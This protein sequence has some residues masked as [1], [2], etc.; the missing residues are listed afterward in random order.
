MNFKI[1][2]RT[3]QATPQPPF[4]RLLKVLERLSKL[5]GPQ[6]FA[7]KLLVG[8]GVDQASGGEIAKHLIGTLRLAYDTFTGQPILHFDTSLGRVDVRNPWVVGGVA[9]VDQSFEFQGWKRDP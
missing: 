1:G 9:V 6:R 2:Q 7:I 4:P 5:P 3:V 8:I